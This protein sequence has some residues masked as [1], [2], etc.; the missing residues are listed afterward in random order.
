MDYFQLIF[1]PPKFENDPEKTSRA[2]LLHLA[3]T[4]L[5]F[6][7]IPLIILN[8]IFG[9][10]AEQSIN[11]VLAGIILL[12]IPVQLL[13]R[14]GRV[15]IASW[16]LL[17]LSWVA[18]TW[19]ASQVEGVGDVA[20]VCYFLILLG[21]G[22]LLG[23]RAVTILTTWTI[24]AVWV[25]A[26]YES[27][28]L[29]RP[30]PGNPIRIAVDLTVIFI[31]ASLE[32]Y[33]VITALTRS[34]NSANNE[35]KERQR[36]ETILRDEREKLSIALQSAK[37][38]TWDWNIETGTVSWSDGIEAMFGMAPGQFDGKYESYLMLIHP[39]DLP[40]LQQAISR[41]LA[42]ANYA[43]VIEH[44][45]TRPDGKACWLEGRG[46][47]YRNA[48]GSPIRMAGTVVDVTD[49]KL[50]EMERERLLRELGAKNN[51]LE[52]FTYT[53]SHDLKAPLI[54]IKGFM[55][56]LE[57]DA[58]AGN[59]DR[60]HKDV[61]R[62]NDAVDKMHRLLM[63]LLE[64]SRIGRMVNVSTPIS[65][66]S[67][68]NEALELV[69]GRLK[70][71]GVKVVVANDLPVV[72]GDRQRL[73]E[74]LQNLLDNAAKFMGDQAAPLIEVGLKH[75]EDHL[76]VFFVRD[77]GIGIPPEHHERIFGLFNKLD[78]SAEGTG[79]GLA[80]VK[81]IVEF[82]GGRIWVESGLQAG[83][84]FYFTLPIAQ[85]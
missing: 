10:Q 78:P 4:V 57:Q 56:F 21:A 32:I 54:T 70:M 28:G 31:I 2:F 8:L 85:S 42:D 62:I 76:P 16:L 29:I 7:P 40:E 9:N 80:L 77:N 46:K 24:L 72:H 43:Y 84:T 19:I 20:V 37:M 49:R 61:M 75:Y 45:L 33:F 6:A 79:V 64:L 58:L 44:R 55:G 12:Q 63:E 66:E 73:L 34:L 65:F 13:V 52:Q 81:R 23:W 26:I 53:V 30:V 38:E 14:S 41:S 22:Y 3:S 39:D 1:S 18:M 59:Q 74:V 27:T 35:L 5:F 48:S 71:R 11:I 67:L 51:E 68:V 25:L 17:L 47:V 83:T 36:V 82:H 50:A 60:V 15:H 69:H